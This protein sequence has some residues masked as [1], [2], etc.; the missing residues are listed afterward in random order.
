MTGF[1]EE[2]KK[3]GGCAWVLY[4]YGIFM[5]G[6]MVYWFASGGDPEVKQFRDDC[7]H[8]GMARYYPG[9]VPD[10]A[11]MGIVQACDKALQQFLDERRAR[12]AH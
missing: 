2:L 10:A 9:D 12:N 6:Y 7:H 5:V 1:V 8:R 3:Q 11:L 4:A